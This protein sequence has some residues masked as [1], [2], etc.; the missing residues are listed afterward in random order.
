MKHGLLLQAVTAYAHVGIGKNNTSL[1]E[2]CQWLAWCVR[3]ARLDF[4]ASLAILK[5]RYIL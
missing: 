1:R 3:E 5:K 2:A 4:L